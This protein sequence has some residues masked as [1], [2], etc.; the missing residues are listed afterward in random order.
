M[1][2]LVGALS[3]IST[4][5][6]GL[7]GIRYKDKLHL[8]LGFSAGAVMGVA[9]F[10][11]IP[12]SI[13]LASQAYDM[14]LIMPVMAFG[15][16]LYMLMGRSYTM[17]H[18]HGD[19]CKN[20]QHAG[21]LGAG[22][23]CLHSFLD[24]MAIGLAFKVNP[25]IGWV[26]SSAVLVHNFSDGLN[27]VNMILKERDNKALALKW[28]IADALSP[29]IGITVATYFLVVSEPVLGLIL[30]LFTGFFL[31]IGASDLVP[32]SHHRHPTFLTSAMTVFG[33]VVIY[34]VVS[35][36]H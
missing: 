4:S 22:A 17:G 6:G 33:M 20:E 18:C 34:F 10:D 5:L 8:I 9:F 28:L 13:E 11:L 25:S 14:H 24:G 19:D 7:F 29:I 3:I 36:A 1:A 31:F 32:E 2:F 15:F 35:L 30:S 16:I 23:F 21:H 12:E 27:T 26:V